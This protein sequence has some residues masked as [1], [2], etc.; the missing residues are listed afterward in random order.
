MVH[1]L[2]FPIKCVWVLGLVVS[3]FG[4]VQEYYVRHVVEK[5][6]RIIIEDF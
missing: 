6:L 5:C 4:L 1:Q 2:E 3:S